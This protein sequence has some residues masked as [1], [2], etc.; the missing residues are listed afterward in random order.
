MNLY[1][2]NLDSRADR[3]ARMVKDWSREMNLYR[4]PGVKIES[5]KFGA[6][7]CFQAHENA[8]RKVRKSKTLSIIAEDDIVPTNNFTN[9]LIS[10]INNLPDD[11]VML[12]VG[13]NI[14]EAS[15]FTPMKGGI[16]KAGSDITAGHCYIVNPKFYP[17][18]D[19]VL[20]LE[21]GSKHSNFDMLLLNLQKKHSVYMCTPALCYQYESFSD[22]SNR[23]VGNT[24][25][26]K[27]YFQE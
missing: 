27:K 18:Y 13:F 20:S 15:V 5:E 6:K 8:F 7:G 12:M 23:V 3:L 2:I 11:W 25:S 19:Y 4:I 9:K 26:T 24:E 16:S 21:A 22:N 10:C 1:F 14:S 17:I